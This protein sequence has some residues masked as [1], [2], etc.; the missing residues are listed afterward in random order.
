MDEPRKKHAE[1]PLIL[2]LVKRTAIFLFFI[3]AVSIFYWIVGSLSSFLDST[4][5]ML[6]DIMRISSLGVMTASG[7][8]MLFSLVLS[9]ARRFRPSLVGLLGYL[10]AAGV[11]GLALAISQSISILS[12]GIR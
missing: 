2:I 10:I 1:K 11:G 5:T 12:L 3:C 7:L 6:L 8:G 4:Q 9:I